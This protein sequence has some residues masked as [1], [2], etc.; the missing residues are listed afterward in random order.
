MQPWYFKRTLRRLGYRYDRFIDPGW[1]HYRWLV[2]GLCDHDPA[3]AAQIALKQPSTGRRNHFRGAI[4]DLPGFALCPVWALD[5]F[6]Q[7]ASLKACAVICDK[8][9]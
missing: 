4:D 7:E 8:V 2:L 9:R 5:D 1:D 6:P 3:I